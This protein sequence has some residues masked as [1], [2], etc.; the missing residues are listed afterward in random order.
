MS[1]VQLL[2]SFA[3]EGEPKDFYVVST[4]SVLNGGLVRGDQFLNVCPNP[5]TAT[6]GGDDDDDANGT[7]V[8]AAAAAA[9]AATTLLG[10]GRRRILEDGPPPAPAPTRPSE[11][12][13]KCCMGAPGA[14]YVVACIV[15]EF[16]D[17]K[18]YGKVPWDPK[19]KPNECE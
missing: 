10:N 19:V 11:K 17:D 2:A 1:Y 14:V 8:A 15:K 6:V 3:P 4:A 7:S 16:P 12:K 13:G 18:L 9:A 5:T